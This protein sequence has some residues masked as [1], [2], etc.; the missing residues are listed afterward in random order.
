[1]SESDDNPYKSPLSTCVEAADVSCSFCNRPGKQAG[2]L[3]QSRTGDSFIC[4]SCVE[5]CKEIFE[6]KRQPLIVRCATAIFTFSFYVIAICATSYDAFI[7]TEP[8]LSRVLTVPIL[9]MLII[10]VVLGIVTM[11]RTSR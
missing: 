3:V 8:Q 2:R 1:M 10:G 7:A 4:R 6:S 11:L 5:L 9:L